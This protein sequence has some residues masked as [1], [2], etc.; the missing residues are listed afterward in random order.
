[1]LCI[2][3]QTAV[4]FR[5]RSRYAFVQQLQHNSFF[6]YYILYH[7][8]YIGYTIRIVFDLG[9][10]LNL[11]FLKRW[12][13]SN[14]AVR[15]IINGHTKSFS[16]ATKSRSYSLIAPP[17]PWVSSICPRSQ[18]GRGFVAYLTVFILIQYVYH[19]VF[20]PVSSAKFICHIAG[21]VHGIIHVIC[22]KQTG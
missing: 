2:G 18:S 1:M 13:I 6:V 16:E 17:P 19:N 10:A 7:L 20:Y 8:D 3:C 22:I 5:Y 12:T 14:K 21:K 11:L 15:M 4:K 9:I